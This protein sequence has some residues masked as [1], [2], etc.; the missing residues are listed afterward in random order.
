[1]LESGANPAAYPANYLVDNFQFYKSAYAENDYQVYSL[2][3][4]YVAASNRLIVTWERDKPEDTVAQEVRY[5]FQD[6]HQIGWAAATPAPGGLVAPP[7]PGGYNNMVY[8]TTALPLAGH[9][10]V[11]IAIKPQNSN[12]FSEIKV[13]LNV[14]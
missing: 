3:A 11:Y 7:G 9:Q 4:T 5:S 10:Y 6:I 13:P 8:N 14:G 2:A 1:Y 12:L